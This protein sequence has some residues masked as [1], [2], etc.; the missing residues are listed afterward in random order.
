MSLCLIWRRQCLAQQEI[1]CTLL[2]ILQI[3][4]ELFKDCQEF[5]GALIDDMSRIVVLLRV[6]KNKAH[7]FSRLV[8][9]TVPPSHQPIEHDIQ[10]HGTLYNLCV[11]LW[12]QGHK[13]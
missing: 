10:A 12:R 3:S 2:S 1:L 8:L 7:V 9:V 11:E 13:E 5:S 4:E 6:A